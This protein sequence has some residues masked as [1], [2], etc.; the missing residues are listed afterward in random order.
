M[1]DLKVVTLDKDNGLDQNRTTEGLYYANFV[2][3]KKLVHELSEGSDNIDNGLV[4]QDIDKLSPYLQSYMKKR[5]GDSICG[6][7]VCVA[8][9]YSYPNT[10]AD[11]NNFYRQPDTFIPNGMKTNEE[12]AFGCT[13]DYYENTALIKNQQTENGIYN[14]YLSSGQHTMKSD[15]EYYAQQIRQSSMAEVYTTKS[16][17]VLRES[18]DSTETA[19]VR[20][21]ADQP[22]VPYMNVT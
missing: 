15:L 17:P 16:I 6:A 12:F 3:R 7:Y 18:V 5:F 2:F 9:V 10:D 11:I 20:V 8:D 4:Y 21:Y 14:Q 1:G 22:H 19:Q 13:D